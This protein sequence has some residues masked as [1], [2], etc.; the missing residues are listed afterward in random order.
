MRDKK[1]VG[2]FLI[3]TFVMSC[4]CYFIRIAGGDAA[5]GMTGV[6]MWCPG[7]A[8]FI[9]QRVFYRG[10]KILGFAK[11][12]ISYSFVAFLIPILYLGISY[13]AYWFIDKGSFGGQLY[14]NSILM[15][16]ILMPSTFIT[17]LGEEIGWRGFLLPK[18]SEIWGTRTAIVLSGAIW[19]VWHFP[20]MLAG[21]YQTG[22]PVWYQLSVFTVEIIAMGGILAFMRLKS[23][24]V[25]P[26]AILH[27]SHNY[28]DQVIFGPLTN[29]GISVYFVG[30]TGIITAITLIVVVLIIKRRRGV[31]V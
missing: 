11:S 17:A 15:L 28:F 26:A 7:I 20:L 29:S 6:L 25:W 21:L 5:N 24:S 23:D 8:A 13:S 2:L 1:A 18:M 12:K 9:V 14:T 22:T 30:E 19:S 16:L 10:Q 31:R 4:V 27:M 3:L